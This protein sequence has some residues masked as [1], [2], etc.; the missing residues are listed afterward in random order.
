MTDELILEEDIILLLAAER[1][2]DIDQDITRALSIASTPPAG[3]PRIDRP[4]FGNLKGRK[5]EA[6]FRL[7][8]GRVYRY[9]MAM[10]AAVERYKE[11]HPNWKDALPRLSFGPLHHIDHLQIA[12][13]QAYA[14]SPRKEA[15]A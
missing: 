9:S 11:A 14:A 2:G 6:A 3:W 13:W 4:D 5:R 8:M 12:G 1:M 10:Y 7:W 15:I